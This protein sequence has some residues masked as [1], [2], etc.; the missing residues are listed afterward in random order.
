MNE[1]DPPIVVVDPDFAASIAAGLTE[2]FEDYC[3]R[4]ATRD[5][6]AT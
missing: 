5:E 3:T 4:S 6:E 2:T 1:T